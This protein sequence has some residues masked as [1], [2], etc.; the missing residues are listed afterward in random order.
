MDPINQ[1][2]IVAI[3]VPTIAVEPTRHCKIKIEEEKYSGMDGN[4]K[5]YTLYT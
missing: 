3:R 2:S 1:C 4:K 5:G